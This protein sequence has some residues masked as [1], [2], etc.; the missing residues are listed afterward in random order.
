MQSI[1]LLVLWNSEILGSCQKGRALNG[2]G[3]G[4]VGAAG[5]RVHDGRRPQGRRL[6]GAAVAARRARQEVQPCGGLRAGPGRR[7]PP[8]QA[9]ARPHHLCGGHPVRPG[10]PAATWRPC[11]HSDPPATACVDAERSPPRTSVAYLRGS[12]PLR[13]KRSRRNKRL[14]MISSSVWESFRNVSAQR[15]TP[16]VRWMAGW[17]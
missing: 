13:H 12:E 9:R 2:S 17:S 1:T 5:A 7:L 16:H 10:T 6:R 11:G 4:A 15:C 8:R 14:P 3:P